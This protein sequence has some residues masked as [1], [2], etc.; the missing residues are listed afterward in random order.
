MILDHLASLKHQ[1]ASLRQRIDL[2]AAAQKIAFG[3]AALL[4]SYVLYLTISIFLSLEK[5]LKA[6]II[7]GF[8]AFGVAL[9]SNHIQK[10]REME[11]KI[12]ERKTEAYQKV[13]DFLLFILKGMRNDGLSE[14]EVVV[15]KIHEVNYALL[16]WGSA[17]SIKAWQELF[18]W[19]SGQ[20]YSGLDKPTQTINTLITRNKIAE[21]I[22]LI[23]KDL[24]H[25]DR[26][27][28]F[29]TIADV[30]M[31]LNFTPEDWHM[32]SEALQKRA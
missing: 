14:T 18:S 4:A 29:N 32:V 7:A 5:E 23:R 10:R 25:I 16:V 15:S 31:P 20:D 21:V 17:G 30:Y 12:R 9:T 28:D 24:G 13:F 22:L 27:I 6:A 8:V 2:A 1:L 19:I 11:F 26:G 3:M